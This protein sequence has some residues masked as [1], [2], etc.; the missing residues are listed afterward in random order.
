MKSFLKLC[1]AISIPIL[2]V[3]CGSNPNQL[4]LMPSP[5]HFNQSKKL[6]LA[7][8]KYMKLAPYKGILYA[9]DRQ[10][11][12]SEDG[13][14]QFTS[15]RSSVIR[16]GV[17]HVDYGEQQL[18]D[19]LIR[20]LPVAGQKIKPYVGRVTGVTNLG[21]LA[22]HLPYGDLTSSEELVGMKKAGKSY[23]DLVNRKLASSDQKEITIYVHGYKNAFNK[24]I[25]VA[26][27]LWSYMGYDG[28]CVSYS[29][30]ATPKFFSYLHD[31][32]TSRV[33]GANL[34]RFI[35]YLGHNTKAEKINI[36]AHSAGARV[37]IT[38]LRELAL[39]NP[40]A[41]QKKK[42]RIGQV[43]LIA[44]DYDPEQFAMAINDGLIDTADAYNLYLSKSDLALKL[45]KKVF[46]FSRLG[47]LGDPAN[48][49]PHVKEWFINN[50]KLNFIDVS[51]APRSRSGN[52]HSYHRASSWVS[53]D[54]IT[55]IKRGQ[56][57]QKRG[58]VRA[59]GKL[60]W[61]FPADYLIRSKR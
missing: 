31:V 41:A 18:G 14:T 4:D 30:P 16:V 8:K 50:N 11:Q 49:S 47:Q 60:V 40:S 44:S 38:A 51:G 22:N 42:L 21:Y 56:S 59:A 9:T 37:T 54:L 45:S 35:Q 27:E 23:A 58:L 24:P 7:Q 19:E 29:W 36:I 57:P 28:V 43:A 26:A 34:R 1:S 5:A 10:L 25:L 17:A 61:S 53:N 6:D 39:A 13:D 55:I 2:I 15:S 46:S 20:L 48:L 3:A 12:Y 33:S 52:G 32:E